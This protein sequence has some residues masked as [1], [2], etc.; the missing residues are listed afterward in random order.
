MDADICVLV[1]ALA[2]LRVQALISPL[3]SRV[4]QT[5]FAKARL[6]RYHCFLYP[7]TALE[8]II[9]CYVES[10]DRDV[11][12]STIMLCRLEARARS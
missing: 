7:R 1:P 3:P 11:I 5:V 4:Y 8:H 6:R 12:L 10:Q 2:K 9:S